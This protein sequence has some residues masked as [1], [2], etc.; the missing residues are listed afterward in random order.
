MLPT[1]LNLIDEVALQ[2]MCDDRWS[3][4]S[5]LDFKLLLP[6]K[7]DDGKL[8]F[9][10]DVC[11]FANADGGDL[12][13]GL[14]EVN[15]AAA[16]I[17]PLADELSDQAERRLRQLI[18]A[19]IEPRLQGV[20]FRTV[21]VVDGYVLILRVPS[22]LDGPYTY[23]VNSVSRRFVVRNGTTTSDMSYEQTRMAF[24]KTGALTDQAKAFISERITAIA[25][26]RAQKPMP[27][28]PLCVVHLMPISGLVSHAAIDMV[29]VSQQAHKYSLGS[30]RG[31]SSNTNLDGLLSYPVFEIELGRFYAYVQMFR[32]GAVEI[33]QYAG[34]LANPDNKSLPSKTLT[35]FYREAVKKSLEWITELELQGS[36]VV[37]CSLLNVE[38]LS[39]GVNGWNARQGAAADRRD[40]VLPEYW[41]ENVEAIT[42]VDTVVHP[43]M[44]VLWQ[45]FGQPT[46][47][48]YDD[49]GG[50]V[51]GE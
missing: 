24:N 18:D 5:T 15:G 25:Q 48:H 9:L 8:E 2:Q 19:S 31:M 7:G 40:L 47:I 49:H 36:A 51:E 11:A 32:S 42:D 35:L 3:E 10:K 37:R 1:K 45:A 29:K 50:W 41:I 30:W 22:L 34:R 12:V 28:G 17:V 20:Q 26:D 44:N 38:G 43:M 14:A 39:L 13:F 27:Q 23:R 33:V 6:L 4:S 16:R 46:C 21:N